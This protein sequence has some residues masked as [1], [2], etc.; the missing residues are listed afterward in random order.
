MMPEPIPLL[1]KVIVPNHA[2]NT[3]TRQVEVTCTVAALTTPITPT[4][5]L[6]GKREGNK[7]IHTWFSSWRNVI[8]W[9]AA[10]ERNNTY[11]DTRLMNIISKSIQTRWNGRICP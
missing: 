3:P 2:R 11:S 9:Q 6:P 1:L 10:T 5:N 8:T 7:I 4:S